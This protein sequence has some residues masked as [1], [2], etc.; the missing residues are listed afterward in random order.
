MSK[1]ILENTR[2]AILIIEDNLGDYFL[3]KEYL[4][5]AFTNIELYHSDS[6]ESSLEFLKNNAH[7]L[8]LIFL[9]FNL[10]DAQGIE[11]V[12][13]LMKH[14]SHIPIIVLSGYPINNWVEQSKNLGVCAFLNKNDL[15]PEML[16]KSIYDCY[17]KKPKL[18]TL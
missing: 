6:L 7:N 8:S 12:K 5:E 9:D 16:K 1:I 17:K 4:Q 13:S 18:V 14:T 2:D 10:P 3:M 15:N 11:L